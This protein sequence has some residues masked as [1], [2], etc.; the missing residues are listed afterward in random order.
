MKTP[1]VDTSEDP[2]GSEPFFPRLKTFQFEE[3]TETLIPF[4]PLFP[5]PQ[6]T[7]IAIDFTEDSVVAVAS[8]I[9]EFPILY[10]DQAFITL[11]G[12]PR[13]SVIIDVV[14][15]M[16]HACNRDSLEVFHMDT[17]LTEEAREVLYQLPRLTE[18]WV[19]IEGATSLSVVTL[20]NLITIEVEFE[21]LTLTGC[22]DSV[23]LGL[24]S[25]SLSPST[26]TP[27]SMK[28]FSENS[29]PLHLPRWSRTRYQSSGATPHAPGIQII[30]LSFRSS[31]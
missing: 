26:Q 29:N 28:T 25:W 3:A 15:E 20:P 16:L 17:P 8:L 7:E 9:S 2:V 21:D 24:T 4:I 30:A 5:S 18:L 10:P 6:T 23:G 19:V 22:K 11:D 1:K 14:S 13:D 12:L 27:I 31:N